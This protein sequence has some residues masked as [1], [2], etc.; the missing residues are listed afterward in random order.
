[1][2]LKQ[3][4]SERKNKE[5]KFVKNFRQCPS[6]VATDLRSNDDAK[7]NCFDHYQLKM[8]LCLKEKLEHYDGQ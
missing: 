6:T 7:D 3:I 1:M 4:Y 5:E 8:M 2:G